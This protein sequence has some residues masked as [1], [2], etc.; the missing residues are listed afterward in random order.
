MYRGQEYGAKKY[1]FS[2]GSMEPALQPHLSR[3]TDRELI[4][5]Q[6]DIINTVKQ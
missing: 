3:A 1:A 2:D 6:N 5:N 4:V